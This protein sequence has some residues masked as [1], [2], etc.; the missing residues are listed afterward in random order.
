MTFHEATSPRLPASLWASAD[1]HVQ[2]TTLDASAIATEL[3]QR[4][5]RSDFNAPGF[6]VVELGSTLSAKDFRALMVQCKFEMARIHHARTNETLIY[7]SAARFDQQKSTQS[8]LDGGPDECFLMLG[9]EPTEIAA[10][11]AIIDYTLCAADL[12]M[13]APEFVRQHTGI[14][15]AE[16][17]LLPQY[18]T[19]LQPF[20][21]NHFHLVCIN[22]SSAPF[23][24]SG[25]F[26]QG[27]LHRATVLHPDATKPRVINSTMIA[28]APA[29]AVDWVDAAALQRFI[30]GPAD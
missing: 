4:T 25:R 11:L 21:G 28:R 1:Y 6:C 12:A 27:T 9:Y 5:C 20:A 30:D 13:S 7:L 19:V 14:G 24:R 18:K 2:P 26:W 16:H 23:D 10:E 22:N 15:T 8:H 17:P 29:N 3:Y